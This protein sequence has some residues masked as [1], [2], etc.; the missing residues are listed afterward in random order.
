MDPG[1]IWSLVHVM[2]KGVLKGS[3]ITCPLHYHSQSP[4]YLWGTS[5]SFSHT[6]NTNILLSY[7][8]SRVSHPLNICLNAEAILHQSEQVD[9]DV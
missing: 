3:P 9:E 6:Y 5:D 7:S 2:G 8:I 1:L 4:D